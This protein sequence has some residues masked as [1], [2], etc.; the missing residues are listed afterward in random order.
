MLLAVSVESVYWKLGLLQVLP[1]PCTVLTGYCSLLVLFWLGF[2]TAAKSLCGHFNHSGKKKMRCIP[3]DVRVHVEQFYCSKESG[4]VYKWVALQCPRGSSPSTFWMKNS[5][6]D[7]LEFHV[8]T[9]CGVSFRDIAGYRTHLH[10]AHKLSFGRL[11]G[12]FLSRC[13]VSGVFIIMK[14]LWI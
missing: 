5:P 3:G 10:E 11:P 14:S 6:H 2:E 13:V 9:C 7:T 1:L 12:S 4:V 8:R